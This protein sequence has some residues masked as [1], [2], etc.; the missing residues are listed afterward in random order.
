[1]GE[2]SKIEAVADDGKIVEPSGNVLYDID[3]AAEQR[4]LRKIDMRVMPLMFLVF[5][6]QFLDKQTI[7]FASVF[8][9]Q[10]DLNVS[11]SEFSWAVS[12]FYFGILT[13]QFPMTYF[14]AAPHNAA[15]LLATRFF[16]GACEGVAAPGF[17]VITSNYYKRSEHPIRVA[18]W[19]GTNGFAQIIGGI[20]MY[21]IGQSDDLALASWRVIFIVAGCGTIGAGALFI[22][23]MPRDPSVARFLNEEERRIAV[24][25]LANDRATRDRSQFSADQ[26]KEALLDL[27]TWFYFVFGFLICM[28][29]PI[30]KFSSLVINGFGFSRFRTMLVGLPSGALQIITTWSAAF[31]MGYTKSFRCF[32]GLLFT[33]PPLVGSILLLC[34]PASAKWGIVVSTWLAA[35]SSSLIQ[36]SLSILASNVKGNTKKSAVSAVFFLA[37]STGCIVSPQLWQKPDAPR[38]TKGVVASIVCWCLFIISLLAYYVMFRRVNRKRDVEVTEWEPVENGKTELDAAVDIDSDMTDKQDIKFRNTL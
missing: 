27:Q 10:Q 18:V 33:I 11:G 19:Q 35:Q 31:L 24:Q 6:F 22:A 36:V 5:F 25:R 1:M 2:I 21:V 23:F 17:V 29:S 26:V 7:N 38:Y 13:A 37:Y 30:L 32:S 28:S 3:P 34:L 8:G 15:G 20:L 4:V 14:I 16:L 12:L 9:L